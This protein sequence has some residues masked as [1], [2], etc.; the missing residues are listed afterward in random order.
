MGAAFLALLTVTSVGML[1][2]Q[3]PLDNFQRHG[4]TTLEQA[5]DNNSLIR[6]R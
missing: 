4:K 3:I 1:A 2:M 6:I 5:E